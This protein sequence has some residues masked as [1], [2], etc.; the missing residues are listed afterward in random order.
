MTKTTYIPA[1]R[2]KILT[3]FLD[4]GLATFMREREI[5]SAVI[6]FARL[7]DGDRVLDFGCGTGTLLLMIESAM[8]N[9]EIHGIDIDP[10]VLAIAQHKITKAN[11]RSMLREYDGG[12]LPYSADY[13]DSVVS[14]LVLHHLSTDQKKVSLA[15]IRRVLKP[16]CEVIIMDFG[17]QRS[18]W[19]RFVTSISR[20]IEPIA[21]NI[22]GKIPLYLKDASFTEVSEKASFNTSLGTVAIYSGSRPSK[23]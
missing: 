13:F 4:W 7:K 5:K 22:Q 1:A 18:L 14:S 10:E 11:G 6:S 16:G 9:G 20:W 3:R 2:F 23:I 17:V 8:K 19:T 15:E 12:I 21:D